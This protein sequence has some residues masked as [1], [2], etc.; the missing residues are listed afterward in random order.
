[1]EISCALK[2]KARSPGLYQSKILLCL[3]DA[4]DRVKGQLTEGETMAAHSIADKG[5]R[6]EYIKNSDAPRRHVIQPRKEMCPHPLKRG[7]TL[8]TPCTVT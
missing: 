4:V 2:F 7:G 1:M 8:G 6:A 5:A 3:K